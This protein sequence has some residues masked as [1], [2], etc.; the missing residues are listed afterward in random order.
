MV[1]FKAKKN[2]IRGKVQPER[3]FARQFLRGF[4]VILIIAIV[5]ALT[6]YVT[7]LEFFTIREITIEGGE[8]IPHEEIQARVLDELQGNFFLIIP[9]RFVYT[10]PHDR[11]VDVLGKIPRVHDVAVK[12]GAD[13]A[14]HVTFK[15]YIP[16]ALLCG[17]PIEGSSCYFINEHGYAFV[18]APILTGGS[19]VRHYDEEFSEI[20]MGTMIDEERLASIDMFIARVSDELRFRITSVLHKKNGDIELQ[21]N[22]G[23]MIL[24]SSMRDYVLTFENLASVVRSP[25]FKHLEPGNFKYID[26]RFDNKV[27]VNEEL[28]LSTSSTTASTTLSE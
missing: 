17:Y 12:I 4:L 19:F 18:E 11:I 5:C 3:S 8:T 9:K 22:G 14:L 24:I 1:S 16:H 28:E 6:W 13:A 26:V 27:F 2:R 10:Y 21:I 7:R 25:E 20:K 15:E 23:G